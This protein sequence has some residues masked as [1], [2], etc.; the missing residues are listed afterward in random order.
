MY[1]FG[2]GWEISPFFNLCSGMPT[3]SGLVPQCRSHLLRT[4]RA[5]VTAHCPNSREF[6]SSNCWGVHQVAG[7]RCCQCQPAY[8]PPPVKQTQRG[9]SVEGDDSLRQSPNESDW[10]VPGNDNWAKSDLAIFQFHAFPA[11]FQPLPEAQARSSTTYAWNCGHFSY[12]G[13]GGTF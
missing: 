6:D 2:Q 11:S 12:R 10:G 9:S 13:A 3:H 1:R 4:W 5:S 8:L 7:N